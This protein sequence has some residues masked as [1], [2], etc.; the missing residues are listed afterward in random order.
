MRHAAAL[1]A[2]SHRRGA[3]AERTTGCLGNMFR[4]AGAEAHLELGEGGQGGE[5]GIISIQLVV[6][7][8]RGEGLH[9]GGGGG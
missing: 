8:T 2:A 6:K 3:L 4:E 1:V 7:I 9:S 5:S